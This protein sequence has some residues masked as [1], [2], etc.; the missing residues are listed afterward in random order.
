MNEEEVST[1]VETLEKGRTTSAPSEKGML[2]LTIDGK[3]TTVPSGT[4]VF[5]AVKGVGVDLPAMCY[6][7]AFS[8]F[9]SCG[10][11]L[12]EVEGK[13]NNVRACTAK[14]VDKMVIRTDT[15]KMVDARKKALEKHLS[16]HPLDCP[17]CDADGKCELQDMTYALGVYDIKTSVRKNIPEDTR[18][19]GLDFNME[20]CILCGQCINVCKEVQEI[21]AL[22]FYKKD[23]KTHVGA[24]GGVPLDCEFCG[25][26]LAVCP[27]GAIVSR[28]SKYAFKPWQLK[29]TETTC[30]YCSD[31]CKITLESE[32]Q[33][34]VRVTSAL[35]Y[36]SKFGHEVQ[37]GEDHGGIC[38]RGR[39]GFQMI[40]SKERLV[41]PIAQKG[42]RMV[43]LP[44]P[45]A[46]SQIAK[47]LQEIKATYGGEA[48]A[49]LITA[50][51]TNEEIYLFQKLMRSVLGSNNIDTSARY[52]HVNSVFGMRHTLGVGSATT[53]FKKTTLSDVILMVGTNITET[54]P[55][56][57]LRVKEAKNKF[58]AKIIVADSVKTN[59]L[60][61]S[62]DPLQ[63]HPGGQEALI[64]GLIKAVIEEKL[65]Y[66]PFVQK[67]PSQYQALVDCMAFHTRERLTAQS[68]ISWEKMVAAAT[69]LAK[70]KRG[71]LIWGE[72]VVSQ[73]DGY[74]NVLRLIDL[75]LLCGLVEKEGAGILPL[76]EENN[77]QG[78]LDMGGVAE[79]LPGQIPYS[80]EAARQR[81]SIAWNTDLPASVGA[82][83]A[84]GAA[85]ATLPE[86]ISRALRGEIKALYLVG[87]NPLGTLPASMR[88]REALAQIPL[89][90]CQD[91]FL[92]A[93]GEMAHYVLPAVTFAEKAGT[94]TN[95][96]GK[97]RRV[98]QALDLELWSEARPDW[99]I[100]ARIAKQMGQPLS[101]LSPQEIA[102]EISE[103]VP[104]YFQGERTPIQPVQIDRYMT[105]TFVTELEG[106]YD[107][108]VSD[109]PNSDAAM[110]LSFCQVIYHSGKMTTHDDALMKIYGAPALSI[111]EADAESLKVKSGDRVKIKT[112]FG[113]V[114][115]I[116]KVTPMLPMGVVQYPEHFNQP[117]VKDLLSCETDPITQALYFKTGRVTLEK[118]YDLKLAMAA[119]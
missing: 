29:K 67:Y 6:H 12:V 15:D 82:T 42:G 73:R 52:G 90:I 46:V 75:A 101:Y 32:E 113:E 23:G 86:I 110:Q 85:G 21:D 20:R 64:V 94:F 63:F 7:Y 115:V 36:F 54:H 105:Q 68:G 3:V 93:T 87:E 43:T 59:M 96:E 99:E 11:C 1:I 116:C 56:A 58:G 103:Q 2:T 33:K 41:R 22:C 91:P 51:C 48:I 102:S 25:D 112:V 92:T 78:S 76:C 17:V 5:D 55:V 114:E 61:L 70:S 65:A 44:W 118:V 10:I 97:I 98:E 27:V 117:A 13:N 119:L 37:P 83:R 77:E 109:V 62:T 35:S 108:G 79:F 24:H 19:V 84:T 53:D 74:I 72:G 95:V 4:T 60:K 71:T 31:G 69:L 14:S 30:T 34:V 8:P 89:I 26:C 18:S 50:R 66:P 9:G 16:T 111:G 107:R 49:G 47:Q 81:F 39:F 45:I 28:F 104:G 40:Q 38:V 80:D 57:S 88:V 106:R 100:F